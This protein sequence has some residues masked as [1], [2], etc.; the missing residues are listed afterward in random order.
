MWS[1]FAYIWLYLIL[2]VFSYG[3]VEW[4]EALITLTFFPLAV[5]TSYL[6][7]I[8]FH[9]KICGFQVR[10]SSAVTEQKIPNL[11]ELVRR[12]RLQRPDADI[13]TVAAIAE[14]DFL[15]HIPKSLAFYRIE[16]S[17]KLFGGGSLLDERR[18]KDQLEENH[19]ESQE[20]PIE[21]KITQESDKIQLSF[22]DAETVCVE[23]VGNVFLKVICQ[24]FTES[25]LEV[26][27]DYKTFDG[28]AVA[29]EDYCIPSNS[30]VSV[31]KYQ[32]RTCH[33]I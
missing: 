9:R 14:T 5:L 28:T 19:Q 7:D 15:L 31:T 10:D 18:I 32:I 6:T 30:L 23:N 27:V 25:P 26:A 24:R 17:R 2:E 3:I 13:K 21:I 1:M 20:E 16:A 22:K 33:C 8:R 4:W 11:F 29:G 12:V